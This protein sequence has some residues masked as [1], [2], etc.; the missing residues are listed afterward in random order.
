MNNPILFLLRV[1]LDVPEVSPSGNPVIFFVFIL[2]ATVIVAFIIMGAS[3]LFSNKG[4]I[5]QNRGAMVSTLK[6]RC[7]QIG[8][9]LNAGSV[10]VGLFWGFYMGSLFVTWYLSHQISELTFNTLGSSPSIALT[11]AGLAIYIFGRNEFRK[12]SN[13]HRNIPILLLFTSSF[14]FVFGAFMGLSAYIVMRYNARKVAPFEI[15]LS[16][17]I[18]YF[19]WL[20]WSALLVISGIIF[21][22]DIRKNLINKN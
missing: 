10:I 5:S 1:V 15:T 22:I 13:K 9:L 17:I 8:I 3:R 7:A 16:G 2:L 6:I 4:I 14:I 18:P 11:V 21:I 20:L 19:P 12:R